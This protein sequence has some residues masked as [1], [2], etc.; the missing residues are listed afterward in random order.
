M[1]VK[2]Y[3]GEPVCQDMYISD[4]T[5]KKILAVWIFF[6]VYDGLG[7]MK[8]HGCKTYVTAN[9]PTKQCILLS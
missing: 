7:D 5:M 6:V 9:K 8:I 4:M 1:A 3:M 2:T